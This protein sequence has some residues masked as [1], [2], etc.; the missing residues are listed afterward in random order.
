M[1]ILAIV[2]SL[3]IALVGIALFAKTIGHIVSVIKLGQ[4]ADRS[5][6]PGQRTVTMLR[7]SLLHTRM[8]QW[9]HVG[10]LHWFVA[11]SFVGL[12]LSLVTAFG[13]LFD[14]HFALPVIGHWVVFEWVTEILSWA[15]LLTIL[16]LMIIRLRHRPSGSEG[17]YSRF[18]GSRNWQGYYVEYTILGV[19]LCILALRGLEYGL[20]AQLGEASKWHFPLTWFLGEA[21]TGWPVSRLENA[22]YLVAMLKIV[23][24]FAWMITISLNATMGVAW[25]RFTVWAEHL[26]QAQRAAG[27]SPGS[28]SRSASAGSRSTSRT[29]RSWSTTRR[30][31][32][33]R[34]RASPGRAY[35]LHHLT[36]S[37]AGAS[38]CPA[39][40][41]HKTLSPEG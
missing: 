1:Q 40:N 15:G 36:R 30:W 17:R 2:V 41:T 16:P 32:R 9:S 22:V 31:A 11:V 12:F 19:V 21:V 14:A 33:A 20:A 37:A 27:P 34:S 6:H 10:V 3:A 28:C 29:S 18:Y 5:D 7:E 8:L 38:Q 4:P 35:G 24:S 13:Q 23:I 39:W 26:V 25:H